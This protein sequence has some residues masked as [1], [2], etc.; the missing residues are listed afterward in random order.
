MSLQEKV[1]QYTSVVLRK[2]AMGLIGFSSYQKCTAALRVLAY[3]A[4]ANSWDEYRQVFESTCG[5]AMVRFATAID[6][7]LGP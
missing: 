4:A 3:G 6:K 1:V 2:D 7:V 5:D